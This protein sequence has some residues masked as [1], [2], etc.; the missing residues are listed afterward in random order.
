MTEDEVFG[1]VV[2]YISLTTGARCIRAYQGKDAPE[3]PYIMVNMM[4]ADTIRE[5][6]QGVEFT[7]T[8]VPNSAGEETITAAPVIEM[9]WRFS[10]HA[11]GEQPSSFLRKLVV[12][13][14]VSQATEPLYPELTLHSLSAIRSI[15]EWINNGWQPRA[16]IDVFVRGIIRDEVTVDVI[17]SVTFDIVKLG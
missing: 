7:G 11:Y 16:Q 10:V 8:D 17:D 2:R 6:A 1:A 3:L 5:H 14:R 4:G 13:S 15:P 9:E 12:A